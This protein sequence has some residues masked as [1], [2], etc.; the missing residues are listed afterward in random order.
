MDQ[1]KRVLFFLTLNI[2]VSVGAMLTVLYLWE[3]AHPA[4]PLP[5]PVSP[6]SQPV[7]QGADAP[8]QAPA[9]PSA[10]PGPNGELPQ[11]ITIDSVVG[12]GNPANEYVLLKRVGEGELSLTGWKL[13]DGDNNSYTFPALTLYKNGAVQVHTTAG[14]DS[15]VDLY[16]NRDAAVWQEGEVITLL[17]AGGN[18]RATYRIP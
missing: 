10:T 8:T 14:A 11:L 17:D 13:Q 5:A 12:A 9:E 2:I 3:R 16:W 18:I 4:I 7:S 1:W 6:V 15:V